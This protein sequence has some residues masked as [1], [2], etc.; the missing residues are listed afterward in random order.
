MA[1][2]GGWLLNGDEDA[3]IPVTVGQFQ[4]AR[5]Q[6]FDGICG[7]LPFA[8]GKRV[9]QGGRMSFD[10][11]A[12]GVPSLFEPLQLGAVLL[13]HRI[14]MAPLTRCRAG[15]GNVPV[16]LNAQYYRQRASAGLIISEATSVSPRGF[17]YPNTPGIFTEAQVAGWR[18]VTDAV[19]GAGGRIFLQLWHVGRI[20][21]PAYQPDGGLPVAPSAVRP[22]GKIF[23]GT[24]MEEYVVPRALERSEIPGIIA[25]YVHGA[26]MAKAAGFDGVEIH[27]ANGY[28][29]DQFLRDG[30]NHRG[31]GYGGS[32]QNRARLTLEVT[33]AVVGVWGED[34]VGIRL[35][36]GGVF[37]DMRDSDPL[38]TFGHVLKELDAL[39]LAYA[40]ITQVTAQDVAHGAEAGVGPRE[41]RPFYH[42]LIVSAGGFTAES[43]QRALAEGWADAIAYGVPFLANPDLPERFRRGATLNAPDETTF[44]APGAKG[45]TDYPTL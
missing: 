24:S 34:R 43:G 38:A 9:P 35:S 17:G 26:R 18:G 42:G 27:N 6:A 40:H 32:V 25:E 29:L 3:A 21:H 36:P 4:N 5:R 37:N 13:P 2:V 22:K 30:T 16:A 45:Y 14:L 44:Y 15:E 33:E 1:L 19:H 31:D 12:S 7:E 20:S 23:T 8:M 10:S 39:R 41:L 11:G 28:L